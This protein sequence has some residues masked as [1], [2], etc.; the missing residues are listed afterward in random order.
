MGKFHNKKASSMLEA[1]FYFD[2]IIELQ[3][4]QQ[5]QYQLE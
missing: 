1:F 5:Q 2:I 4:Y 3:Q